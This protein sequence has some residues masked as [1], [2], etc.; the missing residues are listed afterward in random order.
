MNKNYWCLMMSALV[1]ASCQK[2]APRAPSADTAAAPAESVAPAGSGVAA[3]NVITPGVYRVCQD[4]GDFGH[5]TVTGPHLAVGQK[6]QIKKIGDGATKVC[7]K[8]ECPPAGSHPPESDVKVIWLAGDENE[9]AGESSFEHT[10]TN[11][12]NTTRVSHFLQIFN[13]PNDQGEESGTCTGRPDVLTINF[14]IED[15]PSEELDC[16][17]DGVA[18]LGH[19]H[20]ER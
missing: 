13:N 6:V 12:G 17:G 9:L 4:A 20:V 3:R 10:V 5:G 15:E 18:H 19:V 8:K 11:S 1:L 16:A 2:S 7:L 14:C